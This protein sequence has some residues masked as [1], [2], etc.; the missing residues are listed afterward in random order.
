MRRHLVYS[1]AFSRQKW[2]EHVTHRLEGALGEYAKIIFAELIGFNFDWEPEVKRLIKKVQELFDE[3]LV[4]TSTKFDRIKAF[5]EAFNDASGAQN[6]ITDARNDFVKT[7]LENKKDIE[8]LLKEYRDHFEKFDSK[9]L[10]ADMI[11]KY[12]PEI[13]KKAGID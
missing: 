7:Y 13:S 2:I 12:M 9:D 11:L 8:A 3:N 5:A 4:K 6:Q 1:M 10:L